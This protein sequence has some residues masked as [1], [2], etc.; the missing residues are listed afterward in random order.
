MK[1]MRIEA[2]MKVEKARKTLHLK[3]MRLRRKLILGIISNKVVQKIEASEVSQV[4]IVKEAKRV[5][6]DQGVIRK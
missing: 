3:A 4:R 6:A 1:K 2:E 5:Q